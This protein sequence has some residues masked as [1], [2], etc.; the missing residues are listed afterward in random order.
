[1]SQSSG[2]MVLAARQI[3]FNQIMVYDCGIYKC[4]G[5]CYECKCLLYTEQTSQCILCSAL[6]EYLVGIVERLISCVCVLDRRNWWLVADGCI[7]YTNGKILS[8]QLFSIMYSSSVKTWC[9]H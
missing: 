5:V 6:Y 3:H 2:T 7:V 1:M 8:H 9:M 4:F